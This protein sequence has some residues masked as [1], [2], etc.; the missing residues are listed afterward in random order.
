[1]TAPYD[2]LRFRDK[3]NE[4][5]ALYERARALQARRVI[6]V[7]RSES[8]AHLLSDSR[9]RSAAFATRDQYENHGV[10]RNDLFE[11]ADQTLNIIDD[12]IFLQCRTAKSY[13]EQIDHFQDDVRKFWNALPTLRE[14]EE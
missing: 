11:F 14:V 13:R 3:L 10:T 1:M 4:I 5:E 7:M 2:P 9:D 12:I 6:R 8:L